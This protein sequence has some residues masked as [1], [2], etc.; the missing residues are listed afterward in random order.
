MLSRVAVREDHNLREAADHM[1][2]ADVD[3]LIVLGP[4]PRHR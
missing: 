1:L 3:Q 2:A 4:V